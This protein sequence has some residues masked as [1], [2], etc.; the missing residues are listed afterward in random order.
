[1][2]KK[3][4]VFFRKKRLL[5]QKKCLAKADLAFER[6]DYVL[7]SK[8]YKRLLSNYTKADQRMFEKLAISQYLCGQK[9]AGDKTV[10]QIKQMFPHFSLERWSLYCMVVGHTEK[11]VGDTDWVKKADGWSYRRYLNRCQRCRSVLRSVVSEDERTL[12]G[13]RWD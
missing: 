7:A 11:T 6:A 1:M 10:Q 3:V 5:L 13:H 2:L 4:F 12:G 8:L 9:T